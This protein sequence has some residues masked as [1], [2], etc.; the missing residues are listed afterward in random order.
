MQNYFAVRSF[1]KLVFADDE[2]YEWA[3][4]TGENFRQVQVNAY[5]GGYVLS[6]QDKIKIINNE[7]N[8]ITEITQANYLHTD[9]FVLP[10]SERNIL[11]SDSMIAF[12]IGGKNLNKFALTTKY[13]G[14]GNVANGMFVLACIDGTIEVW[15]IGKEKLAYKVKHPRIP[16]QVQFDKENKLIYVLDFVESAIYQYPLD[17]NPA[18]V[19]IKEPIA[20]SAFLFDDKKLWYGNIY[21]AV[22]MAEI[23]CNKLAKLVK[24]NMLSNS[25]TA[26]NSIKHNILISS[27][28]RSRALKNDLSD[29]GS[30]RLFIG[31]DGF[32]TAFASSADEK[33]FATAAADKSIKLWDLGKERMIASYDLDSVSANRLQVQDDGLLFYGP[34]CFMGAITDTVSINKAKNPPLEVIVQSPNNNAPIKMVINKQGELLASTDNNT[35]KVRDLKTGFLVSEF[36]TKSKT[37]NGITFTSDGKMLAVAAGD[38]IEF[39]DPQTGTA[40]RQI[41]LDNSGRSIHDVE[42]INNVIAGINIHGW[43]NPLYYHKNSG[44]FTGQLFYNTNNK[45]DKKIVDL[46]YSE[47]GTKAATYGSNYVKLFDIIN[48]VEKEKFSIPLQ[49]TGKNYDCIDVL[50]FSPDGKYLMYVEPTNASSIKIVSTLDGK[51]IKT[52]DGGLGKFGKGGSYVFMSSNK[53]LSLANVNDDIEKILP[54]TFDVR[55]RYITYNQQADVYAAADVFGNIKMI[56]G[57]YGITTNEINRWDQY[58]YESRMSSDNR[59]MIFNNQWGIYL[60]DLQN[61]SRQVV[62]KNNFPLVAEFSPSAEKLYFRKKNVFFAQTL[63]TGKLDSLFT[64]DISQDEIRGLRISS[65]GDILYIYNRSDEIYF[66]DLNTAKQLWK[67]NTTKVPGYDRIHIYDVEKHAGSTKLFAAAF[68]NYGKEL[69]NTPVYINLPDLAVSSKLAPEVKYTISDST[70]FAKVVFE[71]DAQINNFSPRKKYH[72]YMKN[73]K[74]YLS[75]MAIGKDIFTRDNPVSYSLKHIQFD[76]AETRMLL[77]FN[78]GTVEVYDL[79]Q[80][81]DNFKYGRDAV[82]LKRIEIIKTN[83]NG[84]SS[85]DLHNNLLLV[86]GMNEMVSLFDMKNKGEKILDMVFIKD[87]DQVFL[88]K[89]GYYYS[90]KNASKYL[91]FRQDRTILP[92]ERFDY[93][94]NRPDKVLAALE[95][96]SLV[97]GE[98]VQAYQ[99]A[100][101]KRITGK[102][103]KQ[104]LSAYLP[105]LKVNDAQIKQ[106]QYTRD[107]LL[108]VSAEGNG[109]ELSALQVS[110]NGV[111]YFGS[112]GKA[113]SGKNWKGDIGVALSAGINNIKVSV[114]DSRKVE[115]DP[116]V[117]SVN[118]IS[119]ANVKP[120]L[121]IIAVCVSDYLSSN[122]LKYAQKDGRDIVS[123][124]AK[125]NT[126]QN[127][128]ADTLFNNAATHTN[129]LTMKAKLLKAKTDDHVIVFFSGHGLLDK[130][131]DFYFASYDCDFADP[132]KKGISYTEIESL[133]DSIAPRKKLLLIDACHSG[134]FDKESIDKNAVNN[135]TAD[136]GTTGKGVIV[137]NSK[138]GLKN[139]FHLMQD[140]FGN[141][142]R[143]SGT[144]VISAAAGDAQALEADKW[145][146]GV[147][148]WAVLNGLVE[149]K[150]DLDKN[151]KITVSELREYVYRK[152]AEE[153]SGRQKP[154]TRQENLEYDWE[155]W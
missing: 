40:I 29:T 148:T 7:G 128:Y 25:I 126:Y 20:I 70:G 23:T 102:P 81:G 83:A 120:D 154:T 146:N 137:E 116:Q 85:M 38:A 122:D 45:V 69:G 13:A 155:L 86:K 15:D 62:T 153:T 110:V 121:Y 68:K 49:I 32:I 97:P 56:E 21:G 9:M 46:K 106:V 72:A 145:N 93:T 150:A 19:L 91:A 75:D 99:N 2:G 104:N 88:D 117:L 123:A 71:N 82:G 90:T 42:A 101:Q 136:N 141:L 108:P 107:L 27:F 73:L 144:I 6:N 114:M 66:Y 1:D 61:L 22:S 129:F 50:D 60:L 77:G 26:I 52:H 103:L 80:K 151:E 11:V 109:N 132:S 94:Y 8:P 3:L 96:Q 92:F 30:A 63:A 135:N 113:L 47:D 34:D 131:Y 39:F 24:V 57:K 59:Y 43:H 10:E 5:A 95:K 133:L 18:T 138:L 64:L 48:G 4:K 79:T 33:Y 28:G 78:D 65:N 12:S 140:L 100:W 55:I 35:V 134:E 74:L 36:S 118:Y 17:N 124:F 16:Y 127:V 53:K 125:K 76:S 51:I 115:S 147:F 119:S 98:L 31:H 58:T 67:I 152:V 149:G 54:A 41:N 143:G 89:D 44:L 84:I 105:S 139:S 87:R 37:V 130:K 14:L 112:K 142:N 111:P